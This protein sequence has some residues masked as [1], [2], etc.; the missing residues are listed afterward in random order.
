MGQRTCLQRYRYEYKTFILR[1]YRSLFLDKVFRMSYGQDAA[2]GYPAGVTVADLAAPQIKHL[3]RPHWNNYP[4]VNPM[5]HYLLGVIYIVLG[6]ASFLGN[7]VVIY[8]FF[9]VKKLRTPSNLLITNLAILDFNMLL[10]N[11]PIFAWNSFNGGVWLFSAFACEVYSF[12]GMV[13]GLGAI[14]SLVFITYDRYNV[15][16]HGVSGKPLTF[17]KAGAMVVFVWAN[18]ILTS[19]PPFFG[20]GSYLPEGILNSCTTDYLS[21]DFNNRS[22]VIFISYF[23]IIKSVAAHESAMRAQAKKMNVT[24]LR[25]GTEG[26]SAEMRVAKVAIFNVSIWILCWT[27]YCA[28]T[29]QGL[30]FDQSVITPLVSML[31]ALLAKSCSTYNPMVY[32]LGHP[33][34]GAAMQEHVPFCC[35]NEPAATSGGDGKSTATEGEK[36]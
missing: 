23:F 2:F 31:P 18:G 14:W 4:P 9:K 27:P 19:L 1:A 25:S 22:Y 5:W 32:A 29:V 12:C 33:R 16:V 34:F 26:E 30:L 17:G 21:K 10:S 11:F 8:L 28:V 15:I 3:V 24:S 36:N 35:V 7:G 20:W 13:T 6:T